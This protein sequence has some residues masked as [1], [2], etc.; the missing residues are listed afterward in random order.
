MNAYRQN[1]GTIHTNDGHADIEQDG[2]KIIVRP[3]WHFAF[4]GGSDP[5]EEC[6]AKPNRSSLIAHHNHGLQNAVS[7]GMREVQRFLKPGKRE[8]VGYD[9]GGIDHSLGDKLYAGHERVV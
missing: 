7:V 2:N 4:E 1:Q 3:L 6:A 5:Y 8:A 9:A